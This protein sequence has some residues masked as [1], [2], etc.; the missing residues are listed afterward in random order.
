MKTRR[1]SKAKAAA[2][3][4][5]EPSPVPPTPTHAD[6]ALSIPEDIDLDVLSTLLPD[7]RLD[8]PSPDTIIALYRILVLQASEVEAT[9]RTLEETQAE[10]GRKDVELD[11]ALQDRES[12]TKEFEALSESLQ[13]ELRQLKQEKQE[14]RALLLRVYCGTHGLIIIVASHT[15]S[16]ARLAALSSSQTVSSSEVETLRH[17]VEDVEREKRGLVDV[18]SRLKEDAAQREG[19]YIVL[20]ILSTH[21]Y[22]CL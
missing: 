19:E 7:T 11:Q 14:I 15:A 17:R 16:E 9:Q 22:N 5:R 6:F 4:T 10:L 13:S 1:Q 21:I 18:V 20:G 2:S 3:A 8:T 12:V